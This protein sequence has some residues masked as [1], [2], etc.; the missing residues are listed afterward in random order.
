ML[1]EHQY[2][3]SKRME[4]HDI[5]SIVQQDLQKTGVDEG[6]VVV[7]TPHTT[8]GITVNE[9]ADPDVVRDMINAFERAFPTEHKDYHHFEGNSHAHIK[10]TIFGPGQSFIVHQGQ[11]LLGIWQGIYLCEFDGPRQRKFYVKVIKG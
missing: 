4:M 7:Y 5:T 10:S 1:F 2:Q 3:F 8:A 6:I 11:L 9:N